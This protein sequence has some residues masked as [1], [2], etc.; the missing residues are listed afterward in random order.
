MR[1]LW[2][3]KDGGPESLVWCWGI[4]SKLL[5]SMLLLKFAKGSRE[6]FH[7]HA[8]NSLSLVL[9]GLL[10]ELQIDEGDSPHVPQ[11]CFWH[12]PWHLIIT[13][14]TTFH[15]VSGWADSN[16][17]LTLRGPWYDT[18]REHRPEL[19]TLTHGRK[20]VDK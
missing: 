20:E 15:K 14:R 19:V 12:F 18:W 8:F 2:G 3:A 1:L 6:A 11:R 4:E 16:W 7:T 13:R 5:G 10:M 17:A 9:S